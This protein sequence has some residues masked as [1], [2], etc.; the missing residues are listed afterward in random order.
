MRRIL[1]DEEYTAIVYEYV[2]EGANQA[3]CV[4]EVADFPWR[5]GF[6]HVMNDYGPN[7]QN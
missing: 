1:P 5:I 7:D 6:G 3:A 4:E 2:E